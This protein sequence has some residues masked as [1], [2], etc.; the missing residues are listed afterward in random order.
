VHY[1]NY[2]THSEPEI[3]Q[4]AKPA[5]IN[6]IRSIGALNM[7]N[8]EEKWF[9]ELDVERDLCYYL[10]I[11][12][13][14]LAKEGMLHRKLVDIL[15]KKPTNAFRKISYAIY[16]TPYSD[17]GYVVAHTNKVQQQITLDKVD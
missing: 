12:E 4:V 6:R 3:G 5:A 10:C 11:N 1:L 17:F 2:F 14:R 16:E 8:L 13:E 7:K 9:F 15:K